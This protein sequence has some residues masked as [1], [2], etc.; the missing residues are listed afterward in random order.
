[1][2]KRI[3]ID[4]TTVTSIPDGL[5]IYIINV[6]KHLPDDAVAQFDFAVLADPDVERPDFWEVVR[7]RGIG[8]VAAKIAPIGPK[9]DWQMSRWLK[10]HRGSY[11]LFHSTSNSYPTAMRGGV[12]T[13]HDVTFRRWFH[14]PGGI[15]G[16]RYLATAY[17]SHVIRTA[18]KRA[19]RIITVSD[20]TRR[21]VASQFG[22][23]EAQLEKFRVTH[24]G[25]EHLLDY[26][27]DGDEGIALPQAGYIFFLGSYRTHKNLKRT[28]EAFELAV[29][30]L[31]AGK[32][33][34]IS[35]GSAKL[36]DGL[37]A[38]IDRINAAGERVIFTGYASNAAI[39]RYY[40]EADAFI[41]PSLAE[42]FGIPVLEAFHFGTPL[43]AAQTASIPEVAGDAAL[44]FDPFDGT[45]IAEAMVRFYADP[46]LGP[47]L[48]EA[49]RRR[50][51][52]FS[53][54]KTASQTALI[55]REC[56]S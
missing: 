13:I 3:L 21:E 50:L 26:E 37:K 16:A 48:V 41:F 8:I 27:G 11:D 4:A 14:N 45:A 9:R 39:R 38:L 23:S 1:M 2:R 51:N 19:D 53:W 7:A 17:L 43:L 25:W 15:P 54:K 20:A 22:A 5:S 34:L 33:L 10:R 18:L 44:Y 12:T 24:L 47:R 56:L 32:A 52:D 31:P 55:Y 49:G 36:S 28:L 6:L 40:R 30:R 29:P 42:G 35:G 46:Q